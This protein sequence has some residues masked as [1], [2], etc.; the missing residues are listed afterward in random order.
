MG[1]ILNITAGQQWYLIHWKNMKR[2]KHIVKMQSGK[3]FPTETKVQKVGK[4]WLKEFEY[5][6]QM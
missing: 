3:I 1:H 2:A 6:S 4:H 5:R